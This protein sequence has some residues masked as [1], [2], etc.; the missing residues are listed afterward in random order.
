LAGQLETNKGESHQVGL[1]LLPYQ[2]AVG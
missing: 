1:H 2:A